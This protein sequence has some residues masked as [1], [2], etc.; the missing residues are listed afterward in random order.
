MIDIQ[1]TE[2]EGGLLWRTLEELV[3]PDAK[4]ENY[5]ENGQHPMWSRKVFLSD[6]TITRLTIIMAKVV[7]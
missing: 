4:G 7:A 6:L 3:K 1:L 5:L 2:L